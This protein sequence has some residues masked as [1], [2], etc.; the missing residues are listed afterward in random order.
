M[1]ASILPTNATPLELNLEQ[2]SGT[3]ME[4]MP[5]AIRDLYN[6]DT[7][8]EHLL[9]WLAW[10]WDVEQWQSDWGITM[11]RAVI[12]ASWKVH[13]HMGTKA[14]LV[15]ALEALG[16]AP[17]QVTEFVNLL[18]RGASSYNGMRT[19]VGQSLAYQFD[20]SLNT[21]GGTPTA[22]QLLKIRE[23]IAIF[24]NARSHLRNIY[25][26]SRWH[27]GASTHNGA[28][29]RDGGLILG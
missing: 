9:P 21:N 3:S 12:K 23:A 5:V 4:A 19:H 17:V 13:N 24:K 16:Y 2:A 18:H 11:Q 8:P 25:Y 6:P 27:N 28:V 14:A 1:V 15:Q 29:M 22:S 7:C 26:A 10:A 20:V